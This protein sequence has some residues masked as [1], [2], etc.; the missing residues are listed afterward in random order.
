MEFALKVP[1]ERPIKVNII[2]YT[3]AI[4]NPNYIPFSTEEP[5][6]IE[7]QKFG[8]HIMDVSE[9]KKKEQAEKRVYNKDLFEN[10]M[11]MKNIYQK[12]MDFDKMHANKPNRPQEIT[13][14]HN[15][16]VNEAKRLYKDYTERRHFRKTNEEVKTDIFRLNTIY[17][18]LQPSLT[19]EGLYHAIQSRYYDEFIYVGSDNKLNLQDHNVLNEEITDIM[20]AEQFMKNTKVSIYK[21][22]SNNLLESLLLIGSVAII[23]SSAIG[24]VL[25]YIFREDNEH[26]LYKFKI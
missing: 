22:L 12:I 15:L 25:Y 14:F 2:G 10:T 16:Y 11:T 5:I 24:I 6:I 7:Q 20:K 4:T 26:K 3:K 21:F 1:S 8:V 18:N 17:E 23:Y 19:Y 13:Q 9:K